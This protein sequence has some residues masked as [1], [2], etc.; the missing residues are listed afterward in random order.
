MQITIIL[1]RVRIAVLIAIAFHLFGAIGLQ[2]SSHNW[3]LQNTGLN[4]ILMF[5]LCIWTQPQKNKWFWGFVALCFGVGFAAEWIGVNTGKLFGNYQYG[6]VFG[7]QVGH[8]PL[9]IG[10]QWFVTIYCCSNLTIKAYVWLM[11]KMQV[12]AQPKKWLFMLALAGDAAL[13]TVIFDWLLEPVAVSLGYWQWLGDGSIPVFNYL[14]WFGISFLLHL[15]YFVSEK[16]IAKPNQFAV[17]L[18][19]IQVLFFLFLRNNL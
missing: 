15:V 8:V 12:K 5:L 18:F 14:C 3:F 16:H 2:G 11:D 10:I 17:H 13:V 7:L 9:L 4:L 1:T 6:A 19:I